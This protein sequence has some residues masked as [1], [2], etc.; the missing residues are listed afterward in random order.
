MERSN[1]DRTVSEAE[2]EAVNGGFS[3]AAGFEERIASIAQFAG[4][5][6][7]LLRQLFPPKRRGAGR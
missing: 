2:L 7:E 6:S 1:E 3:V 5:A 4:S